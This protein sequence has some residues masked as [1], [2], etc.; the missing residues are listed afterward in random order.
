MLSKRSRRGLYTSQQARLLNELGFSRVSIVTSDLDLVDYSWRRLSKKRLVRK[1][2]MM[3]DYYRRAKRSYI[4]YEKWVN[5]L[6]EWIEQTD[7]DNRLI[8]DNDFAK[9]IR[10]SL[11]RGHPVGASVNATSMFE[12]KKA[13][14]RSND[15]HPDI[16]GSC[17][18]HAIVVRG[19]DDKGV[20][21][22]DSDRGY[23]KNGISRKY[24]SGFYKIPWEKF[25][26][27]MPAGDLVL[28]S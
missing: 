12:M 23:F 27:N 3:R 9:Y 1:L 11:N 14:Y 25:L 20:F 24:S 19:C 13:P 21:L 28:V 10:Q 6:V 7:C 16:K 17:V 2:K 18:E 22:V 4:G 5:D 26:V 8:I 15:Q